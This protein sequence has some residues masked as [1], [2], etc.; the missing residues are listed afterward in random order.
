[1]S[2]DCTAQRGKA[3]DAGRTSPARSLGRSGPRAD[4]DV[5]RESA[6]ELALT[7]A[8]EKAE[9]MAAVLG[10]AVGKPIA[11]TETFGGGS[12][13][14]SSWYG[15]DGWGVRGYGRSSGMS[16]NVIQ[17]SSGP[18]RGTSESMALGKISIRASVSVVFELK[19]NRPAPKNP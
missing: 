16:Q 7:A 14:F 12:W 15:W 18:S 3:E 13:Y 4:A 8:R 5:H 11:I 1:M 10:C 2:A 17:D 19:D 9:K 6:R